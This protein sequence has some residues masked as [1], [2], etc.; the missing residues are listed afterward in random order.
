MQI[1]KLALLDFECSHFL[2]TRNLFNYV[3]GGL[4]EYLL[5]RPVKTLTIAGFD[6]KMV[7]MIDVYAKHAFGLL[8]LKF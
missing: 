3:L 7:P 8:L 4:T 6:S 1:L 2:Y 5:I